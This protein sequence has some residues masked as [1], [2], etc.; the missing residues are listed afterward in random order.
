MV[1]TGPKHVAELVARVVRAAAIAAGPAAAAP[2]APPQGAVNKEEKAEEATLPRHMLIAMQALVSTLANLDADIAGLDRAINAALKENELAQRL[3]TIPGIGAFIATLLAG[4]YPSAEGYDNARAFAASLGLVPARQS[5]GGKPKLRGISK[6]G[7]RDVRR[8][9]VVGAA[10]ILWRMR[11][12]KHK[13]PLAEW[14]CKLL[15]SKSFRLVSVALANKLARTAWALIV[16][17]GTYDSGHR[18]VA[19]A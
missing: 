18:Q 13:T 7:N 12:A 8:L 16:R 5:T 3:A 2:A 6:M 4:L 15:E 1:A 10:A 11:D 9:L 14:A 19:A 17:G